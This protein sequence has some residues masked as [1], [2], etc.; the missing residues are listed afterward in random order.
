MQQS[1]I[2]SK[3]EKAKRYSQEPE[4]VT[5]D[6]LEVSFRGDND[7]HTTS[8]R[9]GEWHCTCHFFENWGRCVHTMAL[10]RMLDKMLPPQAKQTQF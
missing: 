9:D 5:F 1:T 4:R 10:E 8:Y 7:T 2:I 3:I 6:R